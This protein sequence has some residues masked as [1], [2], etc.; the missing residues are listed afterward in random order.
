MADGMSTPIE[1]VKVGGQVLATD[2]ETG[3]QTA[4]TVLATIVGTGAKTLVEITIDATTE[5]PAGDEGDGSGAPGP[6][7]VGDVILATDGYP[8][9]V[10]E[11]GQWVD[12][13][14]L[15]PGMWLQTSAGTWV[16]ITAIQAWTQAA[17]VH[18]LTIQSD[19][20]YQVV[21]GN[22]AIL[23]HNDDPDGWSS[24]FD[25]ERTHPIGGNASSKLVRK[26]TESMRNGRWQGGPIS[27]VENDGRRFIVDGHHRT[28]AAKRAGIDVPYKIVDLPHKGYSGMDD[29]MES[30]SVCGNDRLR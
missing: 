17:T 30:W 14:D 25:L 18:N 9:W 27:V 21:A 6:T 28:A 13:I 1:D 24:P 22:Q 23:V 7:A 16:Q 29:V 12:A 2:P 4:R 10:P 20:T 15:T 11:P 5:K 26:I 3:E 8:F 19:H